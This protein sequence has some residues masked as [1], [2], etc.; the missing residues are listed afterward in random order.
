MTTIDVAYLNYR[1]GGLRGDGK[2]EFDSLRQ[3][4]APLVGRAPAVFPLCEGKRWLHKGSTGMNAAC[5]ALD[6]AL[7]RPYVGQAGW[8]R[9]GEYGPAIVWDPQVLRLVTWSGADHASNALHD[10]NIAEF[11]VRGAPGKRLKLKAV[12]YPF[13]SGTERIAEAEQDADRAGDDVPF[14]LV[15]DLNATAS[16][17][18]LPQR[19]W[20]QVPL[21]KRRHKAVLVDGKW[22]SDTRALDILIGAHDGTLV[23]DEHRVITRVNGAGFKALAELAFCAGMDSKQAFRPTTNTGVDTGGALIIDWWLANPALAELFDPTSYE[24]HVP[25]G[26]YPT[27][28]LL[29]HRMVTGRFVL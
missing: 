1:N 23:D 2:Y 18:F 14:A 15:G 22:I 25:T 7:G 28:W 24:V 26:D 11:A 12:H 13:D 16:G 9:R 21:H 27:T 17:A 20:E 29:D 3:A 5:A 19:N 8:H 6:D 4:V 10:R